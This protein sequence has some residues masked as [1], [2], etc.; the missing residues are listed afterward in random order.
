[1]MLDDAG[2]PAI[3][4]Y[5]QLLAVRGSR[6]LIVWIAAYWLLLFHPAPAYSV[7]FILALLS[8]T[9]LTKWAALVGLC[10]LVL[11]AVA[12]PALLKLVL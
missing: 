10:A 3:M 4:P 1:M 8:I 9:N 12:P 2:I 11:I 6:A 7:A 5:L